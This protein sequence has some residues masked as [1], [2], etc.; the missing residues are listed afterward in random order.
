LPGVAAFVGS[1]ITAGVLATRLHEQEGP[2]LLVDIGTNGEIVL[3]GRHWLACASSSAGTAFEGTRFGMRGVRGAIE[4]VH[5][6][7]NHRL[8]YRVIGDVKPRGLCGSG[9]LDLIA[10][11]FQ[12]GV[13]KRDGKLNWE[14]GC[15]H[16]R[17][18]EEDWQFVVAG[19]DQTE[20]GQPIYLSQ[21]EITNVIRSKAGV[22]AAITILMNLFDVV[23]EDLEVIY[24]AGAFGNFIDVG[25]AIRIGLLPPVPREKVR[26]VGNTSLMGAKRILRDRAAYDDIHRVAS[27]MTY[28]D[29]MTN[30][31]YMDEFV[32]A[33]FLPH[34]DPA[35]WSDSETTM[36]RTGTL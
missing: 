18:S 19:G 32:Q 21:A 2:S 13:L 8:E 11:L 27:G 16:L 1:D 10:E 12:A 30:P 17:R 36:R 29:L 31:A 4:R 25:H 9:V 6:H 14:D 34:T 33:N 20:D 3:G 22:A 35:R 26:Y 24:L 5:Y 28:I 15:P 23:P 7:P